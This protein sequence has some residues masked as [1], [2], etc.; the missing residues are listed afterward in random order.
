MRTLWQDL[1]Y[2]LRMLVKSPGFTVVAILALAIGIGANSAI[3]S[4]V[5]AVLL[6]PL[7]YGDPDRLVVVWETNPKL[8]TPSLRVRNEASPANYFDWREQNRVFE[9]LAAFRWETVNLT[10]KD[11]PEQLVGNRV[12]GNMFTTLQV[13]PMLGRVILPEDDKPDG[14]RVVVLSHGLW[15]RRFGNDPQVIGQSLILN[16]QS[17]T[18]IGV[19]PP[20]FEFP[21]ARPALWMPLS[22]STE[23]MQNRRS[24]YLYTRAR[25]KP[26]VTLEQA[27][28][29]MDTIAARLRQQYPDTNTDRGVRLVPLHAD[30]VEFARP[31]LLVLLG[32]VGFVLLI[33]CANVANLMLAR[34]SARQKEMAIRTALGASR[35]RV[36]RQLLTE[37]ML[38]SLVGGTGGLLLA[39]WGVDLLTASIPS[40][41]AAG[42]PGWTRISLDLWVLVFT[43]VIS[44][45]TGILFGLVPAL[46]VSKSDLNET[47]KE[48]GRTATGG[49][50]RQRFRGLLVVTEVALALVL[51]VGAGLMMKSFLRLLEVR[52]GFDPQNVLTME[53]VLPRFQYSENKKITAFFTELLRRIGSQPGVEAVGAI[54]YLPMSGSGGTT[55]LIF[56]GRPAP[57]P[58]QYPE[59]NARIASPGY[60]HA[61]RI[62]VLKG[63]DFTDRD[64]EEK[65][66]VVIIN[67][68]MA[69][70]YY[71]NEDPIGKRVRNSDG[72]NPAEIV[73]VVGD[74]KHWGLDDNPEAFIYVSH[75]Q[76]AN[77]G[78]TLVVRT[79]SDPG[80]MIA[81]VR[82]EVSALDK[83]QPIFNIKTMEERISASSAMRRLP[84]FLLG[85]FA[86]V[87]M[88]LAAV[89][90]YGVIA[91]S[92]TRRTHE[93]GVRMA[94]GAQRSDILKLVVRQG[95]TLVLIG[96]TLGLITS[97]AVTRVMQKML[98]EVSPS[99][100]TTFAGISML[101][102]AVALIACFIPARRATKVEPIIALR[103]E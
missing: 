82:R 81:M 95:M 74:V 96:I 53:L 42:I 28:A 25:L 56:E 40:E 66:R 57:P 48:G 63:R 98:F 45:L 52:P 24:H 30:A 13:K 68:T 64:T 43:L 18:V 27:Q 29:E 58:G 22:L 60:F 17:Y 19:M 7:P 83:D 72:T 1:R 47:L 26:G 31:A 85:I 92:V 77:R 89:G 88:T 100:P 12:S 33:A 71:P 49:S 80:N 102:V 93:I 2:G 11:M 51:L 78:M 84:M 37:S 62:P 86:V 41:M 55:T 79:A 70:L 50:G 32:A 44:I 34:A 67:E 97:F 20:E 6:R 10:G 69:R 94:L 76:V 90:I 5:N 36:I 39:L 54:N 61:L 15:Q 75:A 14:E 87:A 21:N 59:V 4:V 73:G 101:L 16:G 103:Y 65:P 23:A 3:F 9:Q 8:S 38:L 91:Y 99:D 46:Q 35:F